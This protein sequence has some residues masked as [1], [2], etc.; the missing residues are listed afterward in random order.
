MNDSAT[1]AGKGRATLVSRLIMAAVALAGFSTLAWAD[2]TGLAA[3]PPVVW[4]LPLAVVVALGGGREAVRLAAARGVGIAPVFVPCA[5][6]AIAVA[7]AIGVWARVA[8]PAEPLGVVGTAAVACC[9]AVIALFA[10]EITRYPLGS[11]TLARLSGS[12]FV[13]VALGLPLAFLVALRLLPNTAAAGGRLSGLMPLVSL[14]A[15][16]KAGDIAAYVVG[17]LIGWHRMAPRLSPGKTWEG[18]AASI[19]ASLA[20]AWIV[21]GKPDAFPGPLGGWPL[22]GIL[23]GCAGMVGDLSESLVKRELAAKDSGASLGGMGGFLDLV[24]SLLVAAPIAWILWM[25]GSRP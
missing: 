2:A 17:S 15:V 19:A 7:P 11:R 25:A 14:I 8:N 20:M 9:L 23:V 18:A 4:L 13:A 10:F 12:V 6:A 22:F 21:I 5:T 3:A 16:V 1:T 24:D